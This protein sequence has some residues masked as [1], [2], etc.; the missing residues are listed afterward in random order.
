MLCDKCKKKQAVV[1]LTK[2]E[3]GLTNKLALCEDC[4]RE[5]M[6]KSA[7]LD[8]FISALFNIENEQTE[9]VGDAAV[10]LKCPDCGL[11]YEM[12]VGGGKLGCEA[13]YDTFKSYLDPIVRRIHGKQ[14]HTGKV[15]K[16]R[17]ADMAIK[18]EIRELKAKLN[19]A[20]AK[21]DYENAA[22]YRDLIKD[23]KE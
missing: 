21:E 10:A 14:Q 7:A 11:T 12:L 9:T 22:K 19:D 18:R 8:G 5:R 13:C 16:S 3:N 15:I 20:V 2:I 4:A 23:Y 6:L 17:Q 1:F